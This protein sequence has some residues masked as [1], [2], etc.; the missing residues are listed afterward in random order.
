[1]LAERLT[2]GPGLPLVQRLR[3]AVEEVFG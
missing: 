2:A 1:V 3:K